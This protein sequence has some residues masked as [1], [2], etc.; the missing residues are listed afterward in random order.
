MDSANFNLVSKSAVMATCKSS[1]FPLKKKKLF[2]SIQ[3]GR[4]FYPA[5][6][7]VVGRKERRATLARGKKRHDV[8]EGGTEERNPSGKKN[9][10]ARKGGGHVESAREPRLCAVQVV[11]PVEREPA[12]PFRESTK[13]S[14]HHCVRLAFFFRQLISL[15]PF[16][17]HF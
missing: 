9:R 7:V 13:D 16:S 8:K 17:F 15:S 12:R 1:R 2:F 5:P 3:N 6:V 11:Q 10:W 4:K 14:S